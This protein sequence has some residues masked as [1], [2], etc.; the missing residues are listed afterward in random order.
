M[1]LNFSKERRDGPSAS[2]WKSTEGGGGQLGLN[3]S[4]GC[5]GG[6]HILKAATTRWT[7]KLEVPTTL[8]AQQSKTEQK[9]VGSGHWADGLSEEVCVDASRAGARR[10][11]VESVL[12]WHSHV[13]AQVIP[14]MLKFLLTLNEPATILTI[15]VV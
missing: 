3:P 12:W 14:P 11:I 7:G 10:D 2:E 5:G 1:E 8:D 9:E 4:A 13:R 15:T 6:R